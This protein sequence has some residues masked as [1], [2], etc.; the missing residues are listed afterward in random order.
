MEGLRKLG[1]LILAQI[2]TR[3]RSFHPTNTTLVIITLQVELPAD[4]AHPRFVPSLDLSIPSECKLNGAT[5]RIAPSIT[6]NKYVPL[7]SRGHA[8]D[9]CLLR[10]L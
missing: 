3:G 8:T 5:D 2:R 10:N 7:L 1:S 6:N 9:M 4:R